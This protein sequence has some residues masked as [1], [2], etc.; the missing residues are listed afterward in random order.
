M[1]IVGDKVRTVFIGIGN[2][3][4]TPCVSIGEHCIFRTY[5]LKLSSPRRAPVILSDRPTYLLYRYVFTSRE[6][7]ITAPAGANKNK[8]RMQ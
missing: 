4:I 7:K 5:R 6:N 3:S 8:T 1:H 2:F